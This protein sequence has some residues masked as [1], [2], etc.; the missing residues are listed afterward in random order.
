MGILTPLFINNR[1]ILYE[2]VI[3]RMIVVILL[4]ASLFIV[5]ICWYRMNAVEFP[6]NDHE[7]YLVQFR[8]P[9]EHS[10]IYDKEAEN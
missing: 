1:T 2:G 10:G 8:L 9:S 7:A 3:A 4:I 6:G 5:M